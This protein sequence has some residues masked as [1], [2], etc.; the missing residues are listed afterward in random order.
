MAAANRGAPAYRRRSAVAALALGAACA[1]APAL[2]LGQAFVPVGGNVQKRVNGVLAL[3]GYML[4]P[5]VTTG[6]LAIS[7]DATGNPD[8]AMTTL[9]GGYTVSKEFPLYLEGTLGYARYDPTFIASNGQ[10]ERSV[11]AKWDAYSATGGIGWDFPVTEGLVFRP[12]FNF[13]YGRVESNVSVSGQ[14]QTGAELDFLQNGQL[15]AYGLGGSL[16][17]DYERYRPGN[18]IDVE[19]R[20]TNIYLQSF[21]GTSTAVKGSAD[22]Q[23]VSLWARWRAPTGATMLE[24]P[25]R[26]VLEFAHTTFIGDLDGVLGFNY[27]SSVG[28]GLELDS[29]AYD[30]TVTRTRLMA[31]YKVG[32]NV[33]GWSVGLAVSF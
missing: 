15:N 27:L 12:I 8:F 11:A 23:S 5:D 13:S 4:T 3:M 25:L 20:Y 22:S 32:E 21:G 16:V 30:I 2:A 18:E 1:L 26:Y 9:G 17:L 7:N 14:T 24:R 10:V 29:S 28:A 31:R 33:R 19:L 6:S